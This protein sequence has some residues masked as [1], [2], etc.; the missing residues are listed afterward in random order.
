MNLDHI[1][2]RAREIRTTAY[3]MAQGWTPL[4]HWRFKSPSGQVHDMSAADLSQLERI[5]REGLFLT[6]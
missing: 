3:L 5:Q 6:N 1:K 4:G 2:E